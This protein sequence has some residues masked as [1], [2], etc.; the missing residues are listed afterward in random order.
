[1]NDSDIRRGLNP[2]LPLCELLSEARKIKHLTQEELAEQANVT[3]RTIQRIENGKTIPRSYTLRAISKALD[4][5]MK[6]L[7]ADP[8]QKPVPDHT[9]TRLDRDVVDHKLRLL[10]LSC[11]SYLVL[12]FVHFFIPSYLLKKMRDLPEV[13][14]SFAQE[15]ISRQI[16]WIVALHLVMLL[17]L[18]YNFICVQYLGPGYD[19][20]YFIPVFAMY[21][22]NGIVIARAL[23]KVKYLIIKH[24]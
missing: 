5:S 17:T 2:S 3:V 12:P 18:I 13:A 20:H 23:V 24:W 14:R 7:T 9:E 21:L 22:L 11:F 4:I 19:L 1:M 8:G 6:D 10:C 15:L 16:Y